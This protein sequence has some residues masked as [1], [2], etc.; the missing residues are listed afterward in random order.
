M[1]TSPV[2]A[3]TLL[4]QTTSLTA[5][6]STQLGRLT[7]NGIIADWSST[8]PFPG[9]INLTTSHH[10]RTFVISA[11]SLTLTPYVQ[12][13]VDDPNAHV[14][15]SAY[16]VSYDSTNLA[17]NYRGD[18][19]FSGNFFGTDPSFFQ[20]IVPPGNDLVVVANETAPGNAIGEQFRLMVEGF[21]DTLYTDP[22]APTP[23]PH[24]NTNTNAD[25]NPYTYSHANTNCDTDA[26]SNSHTN[27]DRNAH[28]HSADSTP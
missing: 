11:A 28:C 6:D 7:R 3:T 9:T 4:D 10:F 2:L 1:F 27:T 15:V 22:S 26:N 13:N 23:T 14:F 19:G 8:E 21:S 20:V 12:V 17:T 25:T 18:E 16:L 5:G 24:T